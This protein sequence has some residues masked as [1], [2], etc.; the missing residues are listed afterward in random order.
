[1]SHN[2]NLI[3]MKF[4]RDIRLHPF[5]YPP[6]YWE[7]ETDYI[8]FTNDNNVISKFWDVVYY[9]NLCDEVIS[10]FV[11]Q[12]D[13]V[14]EV[15]PNGILVESVFE[16]R[17][18]VDDLSVADDE[19]GRNAIECAVVEIP[20]INSIPDVKF[21][22]SKFVPTCDENNRYIFEK[23]QV[24]SGGEYN[25]RELLLTIGVPVSNQV[26]TIERCLSHI[27]SLLEE[28]DSELLVID[29]G[30][31]D[32][33]IDVCRSFGARVIEFPWCN[34]MSK[35]RNYG[36]HEALGA[37]YLSLDD[38]EWFENVDAILHFF[39]S[40][41]YKS[42]D[43]ATYIQRNYNTT[44][45]KTYSDNH[46]LRIA[47]IT[48]EL[49][50]E[51]RIHDAL[52]VPDD[53]LICSLDSYAHHYGFVKDDIN[54]AAEKYKRNVESLL[55]DLYEYPAN[56]RYNFQLAK[57]FNAVC[58]YEQAAA[59]FTRGLSIEKEISNNIMLKIML[60]IY[61]QFFIILPTKK[62]LNCQS[63]L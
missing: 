3:Y 2:K 30:S 63:C 6:L 38:D 35:A 22:L 4:R 16:G 55:F 33:T 29:T 26:D 61:W 51:G 20:D 8:C 15:L 49:H 10:E 50:F 21:D 9:D 37:W 46:T 52:I 40:G 34:D 19:K 31:T 44:D 7:K 14:F 39:K 12:Y 45:G 1:M 11:S 41:M 48:Q 25:G 17:E 60:S 53:A 5:P 36:I 13:N 32:G 23:N 27:K 28:L 62:Y 24:F 43:A 57:E 59:F 58:K 18:N 56:L 54:K 47:E 42:Y